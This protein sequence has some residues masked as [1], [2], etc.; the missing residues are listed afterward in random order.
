MAAR[1]APD[2]AAKLEPGGV[3]V[4]VVVTGGAGFIGRR[5]ARRLLEPGGRSGAPVPRESH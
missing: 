2:G 4:K 3:C 1:G 5:L